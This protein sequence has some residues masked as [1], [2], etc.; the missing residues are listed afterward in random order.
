MAG[1]PDYRGAGGG[2]CRR[3]LAFITALAAL[4]A[5][6]APDSKAPDDPSD[7]T[8]PGAHGLVRVRTAGE[9]RQAVLA[10]RPGARILVEPG[11]YEGG[12][13][14]ENVHGAPGEPIVIAGADPRNPPVIQGKDVCLQLS[15]PRHL[16]LR[17]M[18]LQ[19]GRSNGL[20]I[21]DAGSFETPALAVILRDLVVRDVGSDGNQDGIKLSGVD[22]FRISSCTVERWGRNG[23]AIDMV[24]CHRGFI[25]DCT[26]RDRES[27]PAATGIQA[28]GGSAAI[29]IRRCRFEHAG[30]R[31]INVGGSTGLA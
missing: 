9:L 30:Q 15:D 4:A 7:R 25:E 17:D 28:K 12:L 26:V 16:E 19:G 3:L 8:S 6:S 27:H 29:V 1:H 18:I 22:D 23:S 5:D 31:A 14:F 11:T 20:N 24:G 10:A 21:D 2:G 13:H